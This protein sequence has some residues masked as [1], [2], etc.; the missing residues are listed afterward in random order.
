MRI[1]ALQ[2]TPLALIGA[3]A[4]CAGCSKSGDIGKMKRE[5]SDAE[6]R[7]YSEAKEKALQKVLGPMHNTVGHAIISFQVGGAVDMYYFPN[8]IAGTAFATMELK[9]SCFR[10]VSKTRNF[11]CDRWKEALSSLVP[12]GF[13]ERD[14]VRDEERQCPRSEKV[15][16][17]RLLSLQ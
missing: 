3:L 15:E 11:I 12:G 7:R 9:M 1:V 16:G 8:G 4:L 14:G 13:Q 17:E 10:R 5:F 2:L 6:F